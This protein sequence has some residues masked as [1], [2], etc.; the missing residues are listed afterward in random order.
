MLGTRPEPH[1]LL[2]DSGSIRGLRTLLSN[3]VP[4]STV[5]TERTVIVTITNQSWPFQAPGPWP[6]SHHLVVY[7]GI[8]ADR[9]TP[10]TVD[11]TSKTCSLS[12]SRVPPQ[13]HTRQTPC[14]PPCLRLTHFIPRRRTFDPF[15]HCVR[16]TSPFS[17][18]ATSLFLRVHIRMRSYGICVCLT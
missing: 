15:P 4:Q 12:N 7:S 11:L 8:G 16:H 6:A 5:S 18:S 9:S 2:C 17:V 13:C 10:V 14:R 3:S 1:A